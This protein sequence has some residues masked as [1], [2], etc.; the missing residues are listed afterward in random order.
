M[1]ILKKN[2][3]VT[4]RIMDLSREGE[5]IGK[6][7]GFALFVKDTVPGDVAEVLVTKV[8][9][10]Y[11]YGRLLRILEPSEKRTEPACPVAGPCGGCRLQMLRYEEQLRLK[12]RIVKDALERIGGVQFNCSETTENSR[13]SAEV[14]DSGL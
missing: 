9:K 14:S 2:E 4:V 12:E 8:K 7:D 3:H 1:E 5:G 13:V 6:V 11:G 10:Q